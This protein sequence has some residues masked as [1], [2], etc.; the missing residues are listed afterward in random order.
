MEHTPTAGFIAIY[1][2]RLRPG[3]EQQFIDAWLVVTLAIKAERG[4]LGSKLHLDENGIYVA[5]A[6]W[7]NR[8]TWQAMGDLPSVNTAASEAMRDAIEE[9]LP[10][11]LLSPVAD[12]LEYPG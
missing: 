12:L 1:R 9:R 6:Q 5:Y 8:E 7:P 11:T 10:S 2:W 4:G 3:K